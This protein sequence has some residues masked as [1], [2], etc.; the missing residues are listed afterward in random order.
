MKRRFAFDT[1]RNTRDLGGYP[2][3]DQKTTRYHQFIRSDVPNKITVEEKKELEQN[4]ITTII[5]LR[6]EKERNRKP[7]QL[8]ENFHIVEIPMY[9]AGRLP[10]KEEDVVD[11]YLKMVA[12]EKTIAKIFKTMAHTKDGILFHCTAGK[13]RTG[14]IS[15]LLLLLAK[16]DPLDIIADYQVSDTYLSEMIRKM[17]KDNP[18][19][20]AFIGSSKAIYM[21][22]FLNRFQDQY[23]DI[24]SYLK[25]I[26]ITE[27][28]KKMLKEKLCIEKEK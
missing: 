18:D 16:V 8:G 5:D 15:A 22:E 20:Q 28:E 1:T 12:D 11:S 6:D 21:E 2:T 19:L 7:T 17:H 23:Q 14:V 10:E 27:K 4:K 25:H 24:K 13:D 26:G 3:L 9:G